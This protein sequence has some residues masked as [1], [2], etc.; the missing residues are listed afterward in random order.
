M[1]KGGDIVT[2]VHHRRW[3]SIALATLL[4]LTALFAINPPAAD[5]ASGCGYT[6]YKTSTY[7]TSIWPKPKLARHEARGYVC[8]SSNT[9]TKNIL[10]TN[11][12]VKVGVGVAYS[13]STWNRNSGTGGT[14]EWIKAYGKFGLTI[15]VFGN[16]FGISRKHY[17]KFTYYGSGGS[18]T[19]SYVNSSWW[20]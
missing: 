7:R 19:Y 10:E 8:N 1:I 18:V 3:V 16:E 2:D 15:S 9:I 20:L 5:A 11:R 12:M 17:H 14:T 4:V 13:S 6:A